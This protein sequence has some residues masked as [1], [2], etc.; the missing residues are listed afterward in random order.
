MTQ[1]S[2]SF[3]IKVH[4]TPAME[5]EY[6]RR[7]V[8]PSLRIDLASVV[9]N[10]GTGVYPLEPESAQ[11]LLDDALAMLTRKAELPRGKARSYDALR[12]SLQ[13]E[14]APPSSRKACV[15]L[16]HPQ[17]TA[18]AKL[19]AILIRLAN[20]SAIS[21]NPAAALMD[22]VEVSVQE[23]RAKMQKKPE[24][25]WHSSKLFRAI[26]NIESIALTMPA[27]ASKRHE[28]RSIV[29]DLRALT[30]WTSAD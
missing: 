3:A 22:P 11:A 16:D 14:L 24:D 15:P 19:S 8:F 29:A 9:V 20:A 17:G 30:G 4:I 10:G 13:W 21:A 2:A 12:R 7:G 26:D 18:R 1:Q 5:R 28:L 27:Y 23:V 25:L 6:K